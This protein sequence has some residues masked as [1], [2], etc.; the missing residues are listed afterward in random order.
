MKDIEKILFLSDS[1][2]MY[3]KQIGWMAG[4]GDRNGRWAMVIEK[5]GTISYAEQEEDPRKVT[6][7]LCS[8][9]LERESLL[10]SHRC[11]VLRHSSQSCRDWSDVTFASR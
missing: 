7:C 3:S 2:T 1:K 10:K 4:M 6:V 11:L 9:V 5:D 8:I